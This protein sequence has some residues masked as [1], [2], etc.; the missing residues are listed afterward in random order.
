MW[1][2]IVNRRKASNFNTKKKK[3]RICQETTN[4]LENENEDPVSNDESVPNNDNFMHV[5][6]FNIISTNA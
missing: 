1:V 4:E 3:D 6:S 5:S 2:A